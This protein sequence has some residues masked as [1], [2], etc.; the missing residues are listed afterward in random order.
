MPEGEKYGIDI[1]PDTARTHSCFLGF[2]NIPFDDN[3][4]DHI[5]A[6]HILEHIPFEVYRL[7]DKGKGI[8][9]YKPIQNLFEDVYRVLKPN[10]LFEIEVPVFP[11]KCAFQ[12][13]SHTSIWTDETKNYFC[14]DYYGRKKV[15]NHKSNFVEHWCGKTDDRGYFK[16]ILKAVK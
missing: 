11:N 14:G 9:I 16:F 4:F 3:F 1:S 6:Y 2:E 15:D 8:E 7:I 13:P 10:G 5:F 12:D